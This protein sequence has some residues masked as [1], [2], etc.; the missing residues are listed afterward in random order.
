[1]RGRISI[2]TPSAPAPAYVGRIE[3]FA[4]EIVSDLTSAYK[5][6][7]R[8]RRRQ[9]GEDIHTY[10]DVLQKLAQMAWPFLDPLAREEMVADQFLT[11]LDNHELR[12]QVATSDVRRIEDLMRIARSLEAV[13]GEETGR[14][15]ARRGQAQARFT[16]EA[17]GSETEVTHIADQILAKIGPELRQSRDPKHRP[18]RLGYNGYAVQSAQQHHQHAKTPRPRPSTKGARKRSEAVHPQPSEI[19]GAAEMGHP[20]ATSVRDLD[21]SCVIVPVLT[22]IQWDPMDCQSRN[23]MRPRSD[24]SPGTPQ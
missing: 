21:T 12:V 5:A 20:N 13:E 1:M 17:E 4:D 8:S 9:R 14:G 7:F 19:D 18:L 3:R 23:E 15:R 2:H 22:F 6:Q 16:D 11:G 24:R 10:V